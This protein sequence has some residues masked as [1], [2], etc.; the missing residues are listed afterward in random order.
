LGE[1]LRFGETRGQDGRS[2]SE[3]CLDVR[4]PLLSPEKRRRPSVEKEVRKVWGVP[5][6]GGAP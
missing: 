6:G 4:E 3:W 1:G 5:G 2:R